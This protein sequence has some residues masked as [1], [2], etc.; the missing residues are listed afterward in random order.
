MCWTAAA[1]ARAHPRHTASGSSF[2]TRRARLDLRADTQT[3]DLSS[4]KPSFIQVLL[5]LES[6]VSGDCLVR[7]HEALRYRH[8]QPTARGPRP[9]MAY[10]RGHTNRRHFT[11]T[12]NNLTARSVCELR[13]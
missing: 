12:I 9:G 10:P 6:M 8:T 11:L 4:A 1:R 5:R 7:R 2:E 3:A 13:R